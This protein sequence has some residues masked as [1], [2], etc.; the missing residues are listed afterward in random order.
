MLCCRNETERCST[1]RLFDYYLLQLM[2]GHG[3]YTA[4]AV[5]Y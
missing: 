1:Q 3:R 5:I 2:N 4:S